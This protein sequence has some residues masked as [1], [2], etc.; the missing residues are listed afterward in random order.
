V[1]MDY[2]SGRQIEEGHVSATSATEE[3][4]SASRRQLVFEENPHTADADDYDRVFN[5]GAAR[6]WKRGWIAETKRKLA[7]AMPRRPEGGA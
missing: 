1:S 6:A 7:A 5:P 2:Q 3:G 4:E